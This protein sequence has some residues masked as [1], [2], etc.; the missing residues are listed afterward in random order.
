M[1]K[2]RRGKAEE[3]EGGV[4]SIPS[5]IVEQFEEELKKRR[6]KYRIWSEY[7]ESVLSVDIERG[8]VK[9]AEEILKKL[10]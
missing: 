8:K 2:L 4:F 7:P 1:G 10:V 6:I 3:Y 5:E 9:E